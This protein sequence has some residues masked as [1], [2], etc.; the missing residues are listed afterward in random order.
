MPFSATTLNS[1]HFSIG[2]DASI[3]RAIQ[4]DWDIA[5][6]EHV[7]NKSLSDHNDYLTELKGDQQRDEP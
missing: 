6:E 2:T 4:R 3:S 7:H 5:D 1:H